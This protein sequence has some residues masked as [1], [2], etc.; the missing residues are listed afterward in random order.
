MNVERSAE[1][2]QKEFGSFRIQDRF[3]NAS[4]ISEQIYGKRPLP[5]VNIA[6]LGAFAAVS[7]LAQMESILRG[8]NKYFSGSRAEEAKNTAKMAYTKFGRN[9]K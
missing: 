8:I 3:I 9:E 1:D 4:A 6:M 5:I 7:E 2:I